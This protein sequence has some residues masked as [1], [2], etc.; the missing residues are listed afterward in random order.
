MG[1]PLSDPES[2]TWRASD[3]VDVI[4]GARDLRPYGWQFAP[5]EGQRYPR[6]PENTTDITLANIAVF[7]KAWERHDA[8]VGKRCCGC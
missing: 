5:G 3:T 6:W 2:C 1:N 4:Y 8:Q 7:A